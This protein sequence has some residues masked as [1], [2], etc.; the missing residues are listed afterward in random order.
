MQTGETFG[1]LADEFYIQGNMA[2]PESGIYDDFAQIEDG[3]G[4]VRTFLDEFDTQWKRRRK[5]CRSLHGALVT[6]K[7]FYP[8][9]L[10]SITRFNRKFGS[11]LKVLQAENSFLGKS[12]TV[13]GLLAGRD[14]LKALHGENTGDFVI[15]PQDALSASDEI[16]LD[17]LFLRD[18][19]DSLGKP[20]YSSGRTVQ[21]FFN[22]LFKLAK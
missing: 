18:L 11:C 19:S 10:D 6:G 22:L 14:I 1:H 5:S 16:L 21:D 2:L 13:A 3:V 7:L 4:M 9:L 20:V 12:I 8:F 17:D 15:I